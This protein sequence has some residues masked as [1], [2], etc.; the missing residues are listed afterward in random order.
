MDEKYTNDS[1]S[2]PEKLGNVSTSDYAV[3]CTAA[4]GGGKAAAQEP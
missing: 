3:D 4:C 2:S 1:K